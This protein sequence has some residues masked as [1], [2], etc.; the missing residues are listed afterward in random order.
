MPQPFDAYVLGLYG[1]DRFA[2]VRTASGGHRLLHAA[3]LPGGEQECGVFPSDQLKMRVIAQLVR[4]TGARRILEIGAGLGYSAFWMARATGP[5]G[6]IETIDRFP[7][8]IA[9]LNAFARR[10]GLADRVAAIEGEGDATLSTLSGPYDLIHDDG[11]FA[12]Q[13]AYYDGMI[14][15]LRPGGLL[16]MSNWFLLEN[17][18]TGTSDVDWSLYAGPTWADDIRSYAAVLVAD[19]RLEVSFI[20]K[21][22][23]ALA[24]RR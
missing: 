5:Q 17:A 9:E 12:K 15:L 6:H 23:M 1:D 7:E 20:P 10:F 13:P 22:A 19:T 2:E 24:V 14:D 3:S 21:P 8:H 16:V 18:V 11:W 4:A